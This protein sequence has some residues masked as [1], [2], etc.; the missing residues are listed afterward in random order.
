MS[1][2]IVSH[3]PVNLL[4]SVE[5]QFQNVDSFRGKL[6]KEY[7]GRN[8]YISLAWEIWCYY[9]RLLFISLTLRKY[10]EKVYNIH[11]I[12]LVLDFE[13]EKT[14]ITQSIPIG[15]RLKFTDSHS[16]S[17]VIMLVISFG[18]ELVRF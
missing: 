16:D 5:V 12:T 10:A 18:L 7:F 3:L 9:F 11:N 2:A 13:Y 6:C 8:L 15:L 1:D 14:K 17:A 4:L